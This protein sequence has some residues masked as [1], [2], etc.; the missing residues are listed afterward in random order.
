MESLTYSMNRWSTEE[1]LDEAVRRTATD[2]PGLQLLET[3]LIRARLAESDRRFVSH[4]S[5]LQRRGQQAAR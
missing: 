3:V 4:S 1:L 5:R 2:G